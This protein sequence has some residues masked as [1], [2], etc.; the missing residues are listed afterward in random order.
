MEK[1]DPKNP[2]CTLL[3]LDAAY[4]FDKE[5]PNHIPQPRLTTG[6]IVETNSEYTFIATNV[7]YDK[8]SHTIVP[9][10]GFVIPEKSILEFKK[11]GNYEKSE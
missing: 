9:I 10:D 5:S 4:T 1:N 7:S 3:W 8:E 6:F 2:V 11:I